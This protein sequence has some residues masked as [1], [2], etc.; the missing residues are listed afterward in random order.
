[1]S[2]YLF[3]L[4]IFLRPLGSFKWPEGSLSSTSH[5][6][7]LLPYNYVPTE[8]VCITF[9]GLFA[10][11]TCRALPT[12]STD[13]ESLI[14]L[15]IRKSH[16]Y[17]TS[18]PFASLVAISQCSSLRHSRDRRLERSTVVES[19]PFHKEAIYHTVSRMQ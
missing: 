17:R 13:F 7:K 8:W 3:S 18:N 14:M 11:S 1:M 4:S 15:V 6:P 19:E 9:L 12:L 10:L 16:P 5:T 2:A